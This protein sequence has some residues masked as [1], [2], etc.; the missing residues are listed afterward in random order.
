MDDTEDYSYENDVETDTE[1]GSQQS[2]APDLT[3]QIAALTAQV[4]A[5]T[6]YATPKPQAP[7]APPELSD[8][9]LAEIASDPKLMAQYMKG[10]LNKTTH[11]IKQENSKAI[12]DRQ[13]EE[14]FPMLKSNQEFRQATVNK[15]HELVNVDGV[16]TMDSPTLLLRA[17]EAVA[18]QFSGVMNVNKD[19]RQQQSDALDVSSGGSVRNRRPQKVA[20]NDPRLVFAKLLGIK[21][22]KQI[23][24]FKAGLGEYKPTARRQGKSLMS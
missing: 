18:A 1:T 16:Y 23:E 10:E 13:A 14:R 15:M 12:Y 17:A 2:Q 19:R 8:E 6:A 9:Q 5:L 3:A 21:D 22:P 20:D 4:Q 11:K 24:K 7:K